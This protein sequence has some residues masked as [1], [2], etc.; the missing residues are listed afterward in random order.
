MKTSNTPQYLLTLEEMAQLLN[1]SST[2]L[3][4]KLKIKLSSESSSNKI[5]LTPQVVKQHLQQCGYPYA[6]RI[7]ANINLR[8]GIGKTTCTITTASRAAQYGFKTCILDLDAQGSTSHAFDQT[9]DE[10]EPIFYDIWQKPAEQVMGAVKQV[11]EFLYILPSS[12]Q[13]A[14]LDMSLSSPAAQKNA[15]RQV[16]EELR[17]NHFDLILIDCPPSL[18][19]AVISSICA[20]TMIVIPVWGDPFSFKGADLTLQELNS[21]CETFGL[22]IPKIKLLF[23]RYDKREKIAAETLERLQTIYK[24]YF[25]PTIIRTSTEF[26]KALQRQETIFASNLKNVAKD[27]YDAF[28]RELLGLKF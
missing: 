3:S 25:I 18:G 6:F 15:V 8:G 9:P 17:K 5:T 1:C 27:D 2:K 14:L 11:D 10:E 23:S 21:I 24:D 13:N 19:A 12:L 22:P 28:V 7:I 4:K 20:A 26:S 16:C